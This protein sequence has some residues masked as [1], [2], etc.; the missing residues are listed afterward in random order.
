MLFRAV[1]GVSL[2]ADIGARPTE[3]ATANLIALFEVYVKLLKLKPIASAL[4]L[5]EHANPRALL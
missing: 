4:H 1:W 5:L 2:E 3:T